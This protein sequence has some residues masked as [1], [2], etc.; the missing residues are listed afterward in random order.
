MYDNPDGLMDIGGGIEIIDNGD[1]EPSCGASR[2]AAEQVV[3]ETTIEV[4]VEV[5]EEVTELVP[6]TVTE[7]V[8]EEITTVKPTV[9][10]IMFDKSMS[11]AGAP[12]GV[13]D[14]WTP[15]VAALKSFANDPDSA[16]LGVALQYFPINGGSCSTG[17]GYSTPSVPV[18]LLP[19]QAGTFSTSLDNHDPDGIGTPIEGALRGVTEYCKKYQTDH[20]DQQCVSV[21]VTDGQP[22]YASGCNE[23][24][25][26]LAAIAK[27]AH[28]SGV[29]TFAV[30]LQGASFTLLDKIAKEGGAPDC[31]SSNTRYACDVSAGAAGLQAALNTIREKVVTTTTHTVTHEVTHEVVHEVTHTE[32]HTEIVQQTERTPLPCEWAIPAPTDGQE[33]DRNKVNIRLSNDDMQSTFV[34]VKSKD[35]CVANAW[36]YDNEDAP[37]RLIACD[38]TCESIKGLASAQIDILLGCATLGPV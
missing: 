12:Y 28:D 29:T 16:G 21:L 38:Q 8:T 4:P 31:S 35:A 6:E 9:L 32:V 26:S 3:V 24:T 1:G 20:P 34:H 33:F 18:G 22:E 25:N 17:S 5:T 37:T 10:Y 15:A 11:M 7:E 14:L 30:G 23:N 13:S 19:G 36:Y 2:I 27:A